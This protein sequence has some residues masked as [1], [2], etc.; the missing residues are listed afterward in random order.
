MW[1]LSSPTRAWTHASCTESIESATGLP[2][3]SQNPELFETK[4][5]QPSRRKTTPPC[6]VQ[7]DSSRMGSCCLLWSGESQ[8]LILPW[9]ASVIAQDTQPHHRFSKSSF[10]LPSKSKCTH[11]F[12]AVKPKPHVWF[13][14]REGP[15]VTS[16][17]GSQDPWETT[18]LQ[19]PLGFL[20]SLF[21]FCPSSTQ[22]GQ[23][24]HWRPAP[25]LRGWSPFSNHVFHQF[26]ATPDQARA[27]QLAPTSST[28]HS[29]PTS[30]QLWF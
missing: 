27:S 18:G 15:C 23:L 10:Q 16:G 22:P 9:S 21:H 28:T 25:W 6:L 8:L 19:G 11:L 5:S 20:A 14:W 7:V 29:F 2:G 26:Q 4:V 12:T 24:A 17:N 1:D 30:L 13:P 3:K